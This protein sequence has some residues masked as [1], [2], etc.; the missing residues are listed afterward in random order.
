MHRYNPGEF[1]ETKPEAIKTFEKNIDGKQIYIEDKIIFPEIV[2]TTLK[3]KGYRETHK[4]VIE[5]I[6]YGLRN[7]DFHLEMPC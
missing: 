5:D 3:S 7:I 1:Y 4:R 2:K 6:H